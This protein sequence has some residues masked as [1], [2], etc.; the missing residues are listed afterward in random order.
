MSLQSENKRLIKQNKRL[1][2]ELELANE[3]I[4]TLQYSITE[5]MNSIQA[6]RKEYRDDVSSAKCTEMEIGGHDD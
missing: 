5:A 3:T 4:K 1:K 6:I 2:S